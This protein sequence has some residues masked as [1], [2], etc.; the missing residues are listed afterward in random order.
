ML[1]FGEII[2]KAYKLNGNIIM[3][4]LAVGRSQEILYHLGLNYQ[5]W[6]LDN[7][8]VFLDSSMAISASEIYWDCEHLYDGETTR[9]VPKFNAMLALPNLR[10]T[11]AAGESKVINRLT[12]RAIIIAGSGMCNGGRI[13]HHL[14]QR[15]P[16]DN[17]QI[18]L[19][20]NKRVDR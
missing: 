2:V 1:E 16:I 9:L 7:W 13:L 10:L 15:L 6:G 5:K 12:S 18:F 8:W 17:K 11:R 19:Q 4:V 3:P 14:K 20:A